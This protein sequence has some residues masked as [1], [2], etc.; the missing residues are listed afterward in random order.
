[1]L[2]LTLPLMMLLMMVRLLLVML[3]VV[4]LAGLCAV[5]VGAVVRCARS[6]DVRVSKGRADERDGPWRHPGK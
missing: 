3:A 2:V 4:L 5:C 6:G 1:M